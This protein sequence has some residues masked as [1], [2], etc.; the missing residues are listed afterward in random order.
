MLRVAITRAAPEADHTAERVRAL[1]AEPVL[2]PLLE[3]APRDFDID[4]GGTQALL[5]T[6][7]N[8]VRAFAAASGRRDVRVLTVGNASAAQAR[9][10]GFDDVRS[11]DGDAAAL[12]HLAQAEL[13]PG[14]GGLVHVAGAHIANDMAQ[15]LRSAGFR[16]ERRVAYEARAANALPAAFGEPLDIVLFHSPRAAGTF[17]RLGAP[18]AERLVAACLSPAVGDAARAVRWGKVVIAPA[19]REDVLLRTA[20]A[21]KNA[22]G[23]ATA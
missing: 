14:A 11:A 21:G 9:A 8:G 4:L 5:F 13:D 20:L 18:G 15:T 23:G 19:P 3:I 12:A 22:P 10:A 6:S 1:G 16:I 2:A 17:V 7:I